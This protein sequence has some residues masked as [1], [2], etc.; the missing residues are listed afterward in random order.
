MLNSIF[1]NIYG[2]IDFSLINAHKPSSVLFVG[3]CN[4]RCWFC[5]NKEL[6]NKE[7]DPKSKSELRRIHDFVQDLYEKYNPN[8]CV[9]I[10]GGEPTIYDDLVDFIKYFLEI[11]TAVHTNG[12]R[13]DMVKKLLDIDNVSKVFVDIKYAPSNYKEKLG[14]DGTPIEKICELAPYYPSKLEFRTTVV[15]DLTGE[16]VKVIKNLVER[17]ELN[18]T[19]QKYIPPKKQEF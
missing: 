6:V 14:V 4:L 17:F 5:H 3:G 8:Y 16:D 2:F 11:D 1:D 19:F 7:G 10:T 18:H 12:I 13:Y 15:P 9:T